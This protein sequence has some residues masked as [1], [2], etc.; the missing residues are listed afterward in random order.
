MMMAP[1]P[2]V[3]V[4]I[5]P[6]VRLVAPVAGT[7]LDGTLGAGGYARALLL[8]GAERVIGVDRDPT[9]LAEAADWAEAEGI[10]LVEGR[11]GELDRIAEAAR[12]L[13]LAGVVLDIGVSSMQ[14]DRAERGFSF[15]KDGPLDMRMAA[16]GPSAADL[17]AGLPEAALADII[18]QYG[19][20]RA[21]RR[22]AR[23]IVAA[24]AEA[25]IETTARLAGIVAGCLPR[26]KPGQP[27]PATRTFQALRIAVNDE[28]GELVRGLGAAERGLGEG[29]ALA[30]VTFHSLEDRIV[31]RFLQLR[32][33]AGPGGSRHA[34]EVARDAPRFRLVTRK[35]V[36]ADAAEVAANPRARS[37]RLRVA[38]RT[39]EPAGAVDAVAL[40]L[41]AVALEGLA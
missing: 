8:A 5:E 20:E 24:R 15:Q 23:A 29:G 25:P 33:G 39:G 32:S 17:V 38:R 2:H 22:I 27:H 3:P 19:E 37:A 41:P 12:A 21:A 7:W 9:A 31:K 14:I 11:F 36:E 4:L 28:L 35:A 16:E 26:Q 18:H 13:P 40:G 34:P 10:D 30:V 1:P 6:L